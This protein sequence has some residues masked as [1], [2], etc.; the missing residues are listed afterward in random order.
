MYNQF[1]KNM[2]W[3]LELNKG[4]DGHDYRY[5]LVKRLKPLTD[6]NEF[7]R[8][9]YHDINYYNELE[10]LIWAIGH[11]T[12]KYPSFKALSWELYG[13]GFDGKQNHS[14]N[15]SLSEQLQIIDL[16]LGTQY[17]H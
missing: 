11:E 2:E 8:L 10:N 15:K 3:F 5:K 12:E 13:Y 7:N 1:V 6:I 16:L 17:W 4:A 14:E 9:R